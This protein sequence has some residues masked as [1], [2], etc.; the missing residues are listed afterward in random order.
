MYGGTLM[1]S[2]GTTYRTWI[3]SQTVQG[4]KPRQLNQDQMRIELPTATGEINFY[5]Y[6]NDQEIVE[7]RVTRATD[8]DSTFFL[9][10]VLDDDLPHAQELFSQFADALAEQG[11]Q[12][13]THI[14]LTC[15]SALTTT[16]FASMMNQVAETLNLGY[17]FTALPVDQ[18][19]KVG[20]QYA[21]VMIAPQAAYRRK[22]LAS[23]HPN[24]LVFEVPGKI[25]GA[26]D[27]PGAIRLLMHAFRELD[28]PGDEAQ[29]K[30]IRDLSDDCRVLVITLFSLNDA[31]RLGYRL[32]DKGIIKTEGAVRK[33]R[34]DYN[35]VGDLVQMLSLG[36]VDM[37]TLD[38]IAIA[39]PGVTCRGMVDLP[40]MGI[41]QFDLGLAL[42]ERFG[43][44]A[45]VDNNCNAAAVGCYV[46]QDEV[47]NLVFYRHAFGHPA[48]GFGTVI[49]GQILKGRLNLAG[50][51]H[52]LNGLFALNQP[53]EEAVWN[54]EGLHRMATC[55]CSS[56][57][58]LISPNALYVAVDTVDDADE[59]RA[60][61]AAVFGETYVPPIHIVSDYVERVYLGTLAMAL[62]KLRNPR[63]HGDGHGHAGP[64]FDRTKWR[65][66]WDRI[67][68]K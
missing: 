61:L 32:Y 28:A 22:E 12:Q 33:S 9:H 48:G 6:E 38:A 2:N 19:L 44:P 30:A 54:E 18:A 57:I 24:A 10:F 27:A 42:A 59:F 64:K 37:S 17:D 68:Q 41:N 46:S 50:E 11:E 39:V 20:G 31:A 26:F 25:F 40:S 16:L 45:F 5:P 3:M 67:H 14:L 23:A 63:W 66:E 7:L 34:L 43:L 51:P 62:Q 36:E 60:E 8:G 56:A 65:M 15:T 13:L 1:N 35:D 29:L 21:A 55:V 53:L 52:Y 4:T 49:G 47:E 58:A